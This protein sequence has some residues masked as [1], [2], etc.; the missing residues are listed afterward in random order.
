MFISTAL[1]CGTVEIK[2]QTWCADE[3]P[4][5][6]DCYHTLSPAHVQLDKMLWDSVRFGMV[7]TESQSLADIKGA[8]E[9]LCHQ[10]KHCTY[11]QVKSIDDFFGH[12]L[13]PRPAP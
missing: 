5:G 10:T 2:D 1:S 9:K 13:N 6:A 12:I 8:I 3:G 4:I 11:E 7:C